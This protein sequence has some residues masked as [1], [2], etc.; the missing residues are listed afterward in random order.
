MSDSAIVYEFSR[1]YTSEERYE[2]LFEAS[3]EELLSIE[4]DIIDLESTSTINVASIGITFLAVLHRQPRGSS[5]RILSNSGLEDQQ[6]LLLSENQP[7]VQ[8]TITFI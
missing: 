8:F 6:T 7:T 4:S 1:T 3:Y 5:R 2:V